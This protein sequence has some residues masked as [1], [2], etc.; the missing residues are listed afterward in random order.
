MDKHITDSHEVV[1]FWMVK[2]NQE[3][4]TLLY[5]IKISCYKIGMA[6]PYIQFGGG[7]CCPSIASYFGIFLYLNAHK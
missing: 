3:V 5:K 6:W 4:G 7:T 1:S 2:M